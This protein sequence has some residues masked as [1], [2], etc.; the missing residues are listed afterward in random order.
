MYIIILS[1]HLHITKELKMDSVEI[2]GEK[3]MTPKDYAAKNKM[4][5]KTVYNKINAKKIETKTFFGK[6]LVKV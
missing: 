4:C 1:L 3:F 5:F 2:A 6:T